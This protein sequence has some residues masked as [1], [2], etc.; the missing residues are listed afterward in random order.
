LPPSASR[1][2]WS[3]GKLR[4]SLPPGDSSRAS[5]TLATSE[6]IQSAMRAWVSPLR[7]Q[8]NTIVYD[9]VAPVV[10]GRDTLGYL[11][12]TR[13]LG[14]GQSLKFVRDLIG[15]GASFLLGNAD[16]SLWTDLA[17]TVTAPSRSPLSDS[18]IEYHR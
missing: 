17:G 4:Y 6:A 10:A 5:P 15:S 9:V 3:P 14:T 2:W 8:Q 18:P 13:R 11:V 7:V 12:E 1:A 16:G